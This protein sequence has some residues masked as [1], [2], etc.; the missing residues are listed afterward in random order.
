M[1]LLR[2]AALHPA[3][4]LNADLEHLAQLAVTVLNETRQ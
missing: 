3:D 4:S 1:I 2:D